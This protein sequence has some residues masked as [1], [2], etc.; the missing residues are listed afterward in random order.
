MG[1]EISKFRDIE[2][3]KKVNFPTIALLFFKGCRYWYQT[4]FLLMKKL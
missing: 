3:L 4:R 1:K 2:I